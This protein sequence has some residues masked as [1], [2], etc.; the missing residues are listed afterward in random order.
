LDLKTFIQLSLKEDIQT[1][2]ISSLA[3]IPKKSRSIAKLLVKEDGI[4]A[5]VEL[6][7]ITFKQ[8][9]PEMKFTKYISDGSYVKYGEIAFE[10]EGSTRDLLK[11]ERFVLN[12]M[13][14]MSGVSSLCA[15]FLTEVEGLPVTILDTRKTTPLNR[16]L[17]KWAV[18]IGGCQNYRD[19]L[20]DWFMIK[21]NHIKAC[22]GS[23]GKAIKSVVKY[24]EKHNLQH[25][26]VTVEVK[27]LVEV[28]EVL[29][30][31]NVN[32]I[33]LDNFELALMK[34]AVALIGNRFEIEAS[35]GVSLETVRKIAL[36]GVNFISVGA[37]THSAGSLDLSLKIQ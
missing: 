37:L 18:R 4:L 12:A 16:H 26:G 14:R 8:V 31:G 30:I 22:G 34:E 29:K 28:E 27:N 19:G 23:I 20:Y 7:E 15:R 3:C 32:R 24:K 10:V 11:T 13:Q 9:D 21:D 25:V 2:D 5:G 33:M 1:G 17:E 36:T 35:G 6:A